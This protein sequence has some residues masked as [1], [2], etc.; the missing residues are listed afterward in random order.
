MESTSEKC[1][2]KNRCDLGEEEKATEG[3]IRG[4]WGGVPKLQC[5]FLR[6]TDEYSGLCE[7]ELYCDG[8]SMRKRLD[9]QG[10]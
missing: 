2:F 9:P 10:Q 6:E 7:Q 5:S 3:H 8:A 1:F 4:I